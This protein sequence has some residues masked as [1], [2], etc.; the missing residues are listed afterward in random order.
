M[1]HV[2]PCRH[3]SAHLG[4]SPWIILKSNDTIEEGSMNEGL[5]LCLSLTN[6]SVDYSGRFWNIWEIYYADILYIYFKN[7][8]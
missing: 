4:G 8:I 7:S 1:M 6:I 2:M 5:P 3:C